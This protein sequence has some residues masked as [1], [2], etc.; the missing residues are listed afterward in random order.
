MRKYNSNS[1]PWAP[2]SS[3]YGLGAPGLGAVVTP[4]GMGTEV[5][6]MAEK[7]IV[8]GKPYFIV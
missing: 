7:I 1:V 4:V 2:L 5:E 8:D 6:D 3:G